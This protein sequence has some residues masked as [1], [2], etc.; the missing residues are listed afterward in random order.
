MSDVPRKPMNFSEAPE[1]K[2]ETATRRPAWFDNGVVETPMEE[3]IFEA[4]G[5]DA[6]RRIAETGTLKPARRFPFFKIFSGALG[7]LVSMGI[8]LWIDSIVKDLFGREDWLGYVA[9]AAVAVLVLSAIGF[10]ARELFG[11]KSLTNIQTLKQ[12][13]RDA[14]RSRNREDA[15]KTVKALSAHL[16]HRPETA[17]GRKAL[18]DHAREIIDNP[19]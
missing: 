19:A 10:V 8:G 12:E 13:A 18:E 2:V 16:A 4:E 9:L 17:R 1:T 15:A 6:E 7:V 5:I 3:D 14:A 11:L